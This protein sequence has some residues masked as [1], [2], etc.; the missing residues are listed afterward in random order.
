MIKY[1]NIFNKLL[2]ILVRVTISQLSG[3]NG[4]IK[5]AKEAVERYKNASEQEIQKLKDSNKS[6]TLPTNTKKYSN[7][8]SSS[9][10]LKNGD[11]YKRDTDITVSVSSDASWEL[12]DDIGINPLSMSNS[13][14]VF[15]NVKF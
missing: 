3:E 5:R 15:T 11:R 14:I 2:L 1:V 7:R 9:C 13:Q 8:H 6:I 4:L 12:E 10:P